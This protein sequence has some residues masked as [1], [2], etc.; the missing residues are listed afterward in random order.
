MQNFREDRGGK[1]KFSG[2]VVYCS[3]LLDILS[4]VLA[5]LLM[6][7]FFV[8]LVI[9]S[10]LLHVLILSVKRTFCV[11]LPYPTTLYFLYFAFCILACYDTG[12]WK[13]TRSRDSLSEYL[14]GMAAGM[15]AERPTLVP[16]GEQMCL[17]VR[18]AG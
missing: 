17:C 7:F 6:F 1:E 18:L 12:V 5:L 9:L 10:V 4:I 3:T 14:A 15:S 11:C 16:Q 2:E 8:F 13:L